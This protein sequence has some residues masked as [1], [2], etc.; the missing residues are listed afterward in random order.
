MLAG[1]T[2]GYHGTGGKDVVC[3]DE[4]EDWASARLLQ[5]KC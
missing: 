3:G 4:E 2:S 5:M 1:K